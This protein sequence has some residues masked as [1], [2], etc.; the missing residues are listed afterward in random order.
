MLNGH[1]AFRHEFDVSISGACLGRQGLLSLSLEISD[2]AS[3]PS[4]LAMG[5]RL[6]PAEHM[7]VVIAM[8]M[9][10]ALS[11]CNVAMT[12]EHV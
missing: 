9:V 3:L 2:A 11:D 1:D 6:S 7:G 4:L 5:V 8:K 12:Y 10:S